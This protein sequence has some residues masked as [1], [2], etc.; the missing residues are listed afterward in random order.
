MAKPPRIL[1]FAGST[2]KDSYNKK[3][4]RIAA[5]GARQAGAEVTFADLRDYPMPL[6]DEDLEAAEG[7]PE[8]AR[9]FKELLLGHNGLLIGA[10]EYNSGPTAVLKNAID[11]A[12]RKGPGPL[13]AW[14]FAGKYAALLCAS[15]G[16]L[17]GIRVLPML[18]MILSNIDIH[19]IPDQLALPQ[20]HEAFQEDG[21]LKDPKRQAAALAIG[22]KLAALVAA[23]QE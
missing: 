9:R 17:G 23:V 6:F 1:A 2:R 11:W 8:G 7:M 19:V 4:V 22:A 14:P 10:A 20:A 5:D 16:G 12:S 15:P 13:Q 3:L 18:R 21:T